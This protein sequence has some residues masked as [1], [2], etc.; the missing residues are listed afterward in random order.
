MDIT[1]RF[2]M[3]NIEDTEDTRIMVLKI[4]DTQVGVIVDAVDEVIEFSKENIESSTTVNSNISAN[5]V[6]GLGKTDNRI[7]TILNFEKILK[8]E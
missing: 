3:E 5:Y 2:N 8:D 4:D 7:I 1:K 6:F